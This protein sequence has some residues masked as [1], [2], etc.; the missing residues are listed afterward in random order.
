MAVKPPPTTVTFSPTW[1]SPS[2]SRSPRKS[3]AV[4][5]PSASSPGIFMSLEPKA[6]KARKTVSKPSSNRSSSWESTPRRLLTWIST[7][8]RQSTLI[9]LSRRSR[10]MLRYGIPSY[11][12]PRDLLD[13]EINVLWRMG[14]EIQGNSRLG[15]FAGDAHVVGVEGAQGEEHRVEAL[16]E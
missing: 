16:V 12:L 11:R 1:T 9:S 2:R 13:K 5:T 10:G 14:V 3:T 6:P 7:P 15:V 4:T 8:M